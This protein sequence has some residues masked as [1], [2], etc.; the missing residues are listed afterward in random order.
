MT[1]LNW[2]NSLKLN[3]KEAKIAQLILKEICARLQFLQD[4]GLNYLTLLR[5]ATTLSGGEAQRIRLAT[6]IGSGLMG[7]LYVLDEP[8]IGL[9]QRDNARL[10]RY[11]EA[12]ARSRQYGDCGGARRRNYSHGRL[13]AGYRSGAGIHGGQ[14]VASR[15]AERSRKRSRTASPASILAG[16][17]EIAVPKKRR[18]AMA[19]RWSLKAPAKTTCRTSMSKFRL[20]SWWWSAAC[21]RLR[22]IQP[23]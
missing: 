22:Q 12:S 23:D 8:S 6:Q 1:R 9:H 7:V 17:Q 10:I 20:A 11:L 5:G 15:H 4:V 19:S 2:F 14:V 21:Q 16:K 13:F 3:D 18:P